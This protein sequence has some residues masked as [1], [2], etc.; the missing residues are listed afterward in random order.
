VRGLHRSAIGNA[1]RS[2][3]TRTLV[4]FRPRLSP[5]GGAAADRG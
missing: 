5:G 2:D 4:M 3:F 1:P